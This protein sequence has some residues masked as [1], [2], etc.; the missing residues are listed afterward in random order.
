MGRILATKCRIELYNAML[1]EA[2]TGLEKSDSKNNI[3]N[4]ELDQE[5]VTKSSQL[6]KSYTLAV[7]YLRSVVD[8]FPNTPWALIAQNELD[9]PMGYKWVDSFKEAPKMN[10]EQNNN[11]NPLPKDDVKRKLELKPK[12]NTTKI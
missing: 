2:K 3:W 8:D 6:Q 11:N 1:A 7:K 4:I 9:T 5:F 12:R 10:N